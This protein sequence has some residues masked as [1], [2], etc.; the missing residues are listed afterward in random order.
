MVEN[1]E[2]IECFKAECTKRELDPEDLMEAFSKKLEA[3]TISTEEDVIYYVKVCKMKQ[4]EA[5]KPKKSQ[6][7]RMVEYVQSHT[8][9]FRDQYDEEFVRI[10]PLKINDIN[11]INANPIP[12]NNELERQEGVM[13]NN[14]EI[15]VNSVNTVK[16]KQVIMPLRSSRFRKWISNEMYRDEGVVPKS[17]AVRSAIDT[18][19]GHIQRKGGQHK[20]YNRVAP[21]PNGDGFWIDV[22]DD[23][24]QAIHVTEQGWEIVDEPP[25]LFRRFKH[26]EA[27]AIPVFVS[28]GEEAK[29]ALRLLEFYNLKNDVDKLMFM[30]ILISYFVPEIEHAILCTAGSAGSAKS[31]FLKFSKRIVD[32]SKVET[33]VMPEDEKELGQQ[34]YHS[35]FACYDNLKSLKNSVSDILC[36]AITGG[37][38]SKRKLYSDDEDIIYQFYRCV[39]LGGINFV[40][41]SS[42]LMD[43]IIL[44]TLEEI[45]KEE[46]IPKKELEDK[47]EKARPLFFGAIL[48]VLSKAIKIE[49][50]L[51]KGTGY[52]RLA[53]FH[54][55]GR[56]IAQALG[57]TIE[58]FDNAYSIKV[59]LQN[60]EALEANLEA[61][62]LLEY[63]Q[64]NVDC[65]KDEDG[66]HCI[67][68][69]TPT[70]LFDEITKF[71]NRKGIKT[72]KGYWAGDAS[73]FMRA[74]NKVK[75]NLKKVGCIVI[76]HHEQNRR[77]IIV[78]VTELK[79]K[80]RTEMQIKGDAFWDGI[81][82][83]EKE[84]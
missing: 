47:F 70:E 25:I 31:M 8:Y 36:Q 30:C 65:I 40:A 5:E 21:D 64:E 81:T 10:F 79:S 39:G 71:A 1:D 84:S 43:R 68:E 15:G 20:L 46:R 12:K 24:W 52:F 67:L 63:C 60:E 38:I 32:P 82:N 2:L 54:R 35:Y 58:D 37:G 77:V 62:A 19:C 83:P 3:N 59:E 69:K 16:P 74:I 23:N 28:E 27:L 72:S 18:L 14:K 26:E 73:H 48:S 6:A 41:R 13:Y 7:T 44:F 78:D 17:T 49:S 9:L 29:T 50:T 57:Y 53:D 76:D 33:P 66:V 75:P 56:A 22:C 55:W 61:T 34:L 42:D 11:G 51:G 80:P 4:D 45:L